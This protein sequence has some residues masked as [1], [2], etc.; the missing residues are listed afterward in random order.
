MTSSPQSIFSLSY[1]FM[2]V[3]NDQR[4]KCSHESSEQWG[5]T[6]ISSLVSFS[7]FYSNKNVCINFHIFSS[8]KT[9][10]RSYCRHQKYLFVSMHMITSANICVLWRIQM[11]SSSCSHPHVQQTCFG[12]CRK[13]PFDARS[14]WVTFSVN[15]RRKIPTKFNKANY[16]NEDELVLHLCF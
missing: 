15:A 6:G 5:A 11:F 13:A 9:N 3:S 16:F 12:F 4:F 8:S 1:R 14:M 10:P 7:P 2:F